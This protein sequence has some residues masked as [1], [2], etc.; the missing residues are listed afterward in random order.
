[1]REYLTILLGL[2]RL[3]V[4]ASWARE[5]RLIRAVLECIRLDSRPPFS[6]IYHR[7]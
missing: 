2:G 1:M 7:S 6:V 3:A 4:E 5:D